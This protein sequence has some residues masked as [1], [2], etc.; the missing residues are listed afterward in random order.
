MC[1]Q[2]YSCAALIVAHL[3]ING[4]PTCIKYRLCLGSLYDEVR[5]ALEIVHS[6]STSCLCRPS[7]QPYGSFV[8]VDCEV[9]SGCAVKQKETFALM[10]SCAASFCPFMFAG[11][12]VPLLRCCSPGCALWGHSNTTSTS[13]L[14]SVHIL[15]Q[16]KVAVC[17]PWTS[18]YLCECMLWFPQ[19]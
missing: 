11:S 10:I 12:H 3:H 4:L 7:Q 17:S 1:I 15:V 6:L 9:N 16:G 19:C 8:F 14:P 18:L 13:C 2:V 5:C